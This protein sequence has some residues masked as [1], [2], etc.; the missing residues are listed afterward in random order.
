MSANSLSSFNDDVDV[1]SESDYHD[2]HN[3]D[4]DDAAADDDYLSRHPPP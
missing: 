2:D 3:A 1:E 4:I